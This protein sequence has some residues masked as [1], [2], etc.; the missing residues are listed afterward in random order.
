VIIPG[1]AMPRVRYQPLSS[2]FALGRGGLGTSIDARR[3]RVGCFRIPQLTHRIRAA[4]RRR[5]R[6]ARGTITAGEL[7]VPVEEWTCV[8]AG[9]WHAFQMSWNSEIQE[10]CC[11]RAPRTGVPRGAAA[12]QIHDE[13]VLW[14]KR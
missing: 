8:S 11:R 5:R 14:L 4:R 12:H 10:R 2:G 1:S 7:P 9:T 6:A 13:S 3:C